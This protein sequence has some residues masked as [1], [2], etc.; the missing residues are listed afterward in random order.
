MN[1]NWKNP[2]TV[3]FGILLLILLFALS[4][5]YLLYSE[6]PEGT[7]FQQENSEFTFT[8]DLTRAD[9]QYYL[10][11]DLKEIS[12]LAW[13]RDDRVLCIQDEK[14]VIFVY[15]TGQQ[16]I[17]QKVKFGKNLDYEGLARAANGR[18]YVL[19][20]DGDIFEIDSLVGESVESKKYE[21]PLTYQ[22]DAEGI[23]FDHIDDCLLVALKEAKEESKEAGEG[24]K[25]LI[26]SFDLKDN[27]MSDQPLYFIDQLELGRLI[28]QKE[29]SY[30]FK[31]SGIAV[32]PQNGYIYVIS[33]VGRLLVVMNR[34]GELLYAERLDPSRL[35][36]PEGICFDEEGRLY[37]SSEGRGGQG[38]LLVFNS[39]N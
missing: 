36:Q 39:R 26:Y 12:G 17:V 18:I 3:S 14:G 35:P 5:A 4:I 1:L 11:S 32:H 7:V 6:A 21:T 20:G 37:L 28:Y 9:Q 33:S 23:A 22:Q 25:R 16:D 24:L 15:Q 30:E 29:K 10:P 13:E 38:R 19:E 8:Y 34:T 2:N 31:P 27:R